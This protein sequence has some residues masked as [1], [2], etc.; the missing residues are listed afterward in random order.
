MKMKNW[1]NENADS[2]TWTKVD[3]KTDN[4]RVS[5]KSNIAWAYDENIICR[6]PR[7]VFR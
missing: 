5:T 7:V 6:M 3:E 1:I 4:G 2:I